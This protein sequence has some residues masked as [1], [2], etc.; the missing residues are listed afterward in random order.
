M[1]EEKYE[2]PDEIWQSAVDNHDVALACIRFMEKMITEE[3]ERTDAAEWR[4]LEFS[5]ELMRRTRGDI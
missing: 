3:R 5:R 4:A 2:L 1:S